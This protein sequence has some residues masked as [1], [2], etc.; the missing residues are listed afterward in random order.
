[1]LNARPFAKESDENDSVKIYNPAYGVYDDFR[2]NQLEEM[3]K[4]E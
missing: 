2:K 4:I 3:D 1:L